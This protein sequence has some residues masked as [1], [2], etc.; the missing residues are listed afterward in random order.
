MN[1]AFED[2]SI[3]LNWRYAVP[4]EFKMKIYDSRTAL[5]FIAKLFEEVIG[6]IRNVEFSYSVILTKMLNFEYE[7]RIKDFFQISRAIVSGSTMDNSFDHD[8]R[9]PYS[10]FANSLKNVISKLSYGVKYNQDFPI[11]IRQME[12]LYLNSVLEENIQNVNKL[13][14]ISIQGNFRYFNKKDFPVS[15]LR[16]FINL[17]KK[18]TDNNQKTIL[19]N[20]WE[21]FDSIEKLPIQQDDLPF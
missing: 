9:I 12:E 15:A 7:Q 16:T 6:K 10:S 21:R 20:L 14:G 4:S 17:I 19:N 11:I 1:F 3:S 8:D 5:Y 18:S 2:K 13:I